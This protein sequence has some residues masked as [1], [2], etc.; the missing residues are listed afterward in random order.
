MRTAR[1]VIVGVCLVALA[2]VLVVMLPG[3]FPSV[4]QTGQ[5]DASSCCDKTF[6]IAAHPNTVARTQGFTFS[7]DS[8]LWDGQESGKK[9]LLTVGCTKGRIKVEADGRSVRLYAET[10]NVYTTVFAEYV[11]V[12]DISSSV[13]STGEYFIAVDIA[14]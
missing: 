11:R 5:G 10:T 6:A 9:A 1:I 4:A 8:V 7:G 13:T 14:D 2:G 12:E 3:G